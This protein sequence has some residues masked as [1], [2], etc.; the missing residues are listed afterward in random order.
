[1]KL[2]C[3]TL[4]SKRTSQ[5]EKVPGWELVAPGLE[6]IE[7]GDWETIH[8]L[9]VFMATPRL[10]RLGFEIP[11]IEDVAN[12]H[13]KLYEKLCETHAD[14]YSQFNALQRRLVSFCSTLETTKI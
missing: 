12:I 3:Q 8:A 7:K 13:L 5:L 2:N 6:D 10:R 9:L 4:H 11:D 1:M 14:G